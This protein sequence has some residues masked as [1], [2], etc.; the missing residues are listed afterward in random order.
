[1][2]HTIVTALFLLSTVVFAFAQKTVTISGTIKEP[3]DDKMIMVNASGTELVAE[4]KQENII[5]DDK[6]K[7]NITIP[8]SETYNWIIA[9]HGNKRVDFIAEAGSKLILTAEGAQFDTTIH[10]EGKGKEIS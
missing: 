4:N 2:K 1:M 6:G 9:V 3:L 10:F 5:I 7:F 8:V